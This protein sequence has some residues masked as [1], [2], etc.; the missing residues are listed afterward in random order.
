M[1]EVLL[2]YT[3]L[4]LLSKN[5]VKITNIKMFAVNI[6]LVSVILQE[7]LKAYSK[8]GGKKDLRDITPI[9]LLPFV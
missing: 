7:L 3:N 9:L 4:S 5:V 6:N 8:G 2:C 1:L